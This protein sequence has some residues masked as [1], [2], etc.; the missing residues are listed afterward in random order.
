MI[1][2]NI[3]LQIQDTIGSDSLLDKGL[4][5]NPYGLTVYGALVVVLAVIV[6]RLYVDLHKERDASRDLADKSM[7]LMTKLEERLPSVKEFADINHHL[8]TIRKTVDEIR[9]R[10]K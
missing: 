10:D 5:V 7:V 4:E 8:D 2:C 3:L 6:W 1:R 9:N